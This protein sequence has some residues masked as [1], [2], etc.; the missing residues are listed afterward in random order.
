MGY[1][2]VDDNILNKEFKIKI[3]SRNSGQMYY[4]INKLLLK[5]E[6]NFTSIGF[7]YWVTAIMEYRKNYYKYNNKIEQVYYDVA[8]I[9]NTTRSRVE[10]SMRT[11]RRSATEQIQKQYNYYNK[12]TNKRVLELLTTY[13]VFIN[14]HIPRI[15]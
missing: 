13:S 3:G 5:L 9:H 6:F 8:K 14:N 1:Y 2:K 10:R 11:A 12:L 4:N 15:D 7:K